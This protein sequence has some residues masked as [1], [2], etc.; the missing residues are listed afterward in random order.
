M[1]II[2]SKECVIPDDH[3]SLDMVRVVLRL[4]SVE[5]RIYTVQGSDISP[6]ILPMIVP[7]GLWKELM[8]I[9]R[10]LSIE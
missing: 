8:M 6:Y 2:S 9:E 7:P 5:D 3:E 10:I 1:R 4:D